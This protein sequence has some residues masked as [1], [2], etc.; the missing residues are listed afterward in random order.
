VVNSDRSIAM[1]AVLLDLHVSI[2]GTVRIEFVVAMLPSL[3]K[4]NIGYNDGT[5]LRP[6]LVFGTTQPYLQLDYHHLVC[7][8]KKRQ[9]S[10]VEPYENII[11]FVQK[12]ANTT[13]SSIPNDDVRWN[14]QF[15]NVSTLFFT[16]WTDVT[17]TV[18]LG[19]TTFNIINANYN[20][21]RLVDNKWN[22]E[23]LEQ[24]SIKKSAYRFYELRPTSTLESIKHVITEWVEASRRATTRTREPWSL[25]HEYNIHCEWM[26]LLYCPSTINDDLKIVKLSTDTLSAYEP[27]FNAV[28]QWLNH[29]PGRKKRSK[30]PVTYDMTWDQFVELVNSDVDDVSA[31]PLE[32]V[33]QAKFTS[34]VGSKSSRS[35]LLRSYLTDLYTT[36]G[37]VYTANT[38]ESTY[39][40]EHV[41]PVSWTRICGMLHQF[42]HVANDP[43]M[44]AMELKH[45]N[46][47][48]S[49]AP[50]GF[51][52]APP[53]NTWMIPRSSKCK[54]F[55]ARTIVY[56]VMTYP[57]LSEHGQLPNMEHPK[58][59]PRGMPSYFAQMDKILTLAT[60]NPDEWELEYNILTYLLFSVVN[61][62]TMS[63]KVRNQFVTPKEN[64]P[65]LELF[66]RRLQG[67]DETSNALIEQ[68]EYVVKLGE[69]DATQK[70]EFFDRS[71][72]M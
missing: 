19:I 36:I 68:I 30:A 54:A 42:R 40:V 66:R 61:P 70:R 46:S 25:L 47:S 2:N 20:F 3:S 65:Y 11:E 15:R 45:V 28:I 5:L 60:Q 33:T 63:S 31:L 53:D 7:K 57:L 49:N 44:L 24:S 35:E 6:R 62:L 39:E 48:R 27:M 69:P 10:D 21:E 56:A 4:L 22:S 43:V 34:G 51:V 72:C 18:Y 8:S 37:S 9:L 13:L 14:G 26:R 41:M 58:V 17:N 16:V 71:A 59:Q 52:R 55:L 1:Y 38:S 67:N 32:E 50:L 23:Q 64:N 29:Q 12:R